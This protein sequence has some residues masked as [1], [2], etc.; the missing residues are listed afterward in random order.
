MLMSHVKTQTRRV[1]TEAYARCHERAV[2]SGAFVKVW[3]GGL[4][5]VLG[6]ARYT[7]M[8]RQQLRD[9]STH[10][11]YCEGYPHTSVNDFLELK[12]AGP[13]PRGQPKGEFHG[14]SRDSWVYVICFSFFPLDI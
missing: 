1:W 4:G 9:M 2:T 6:Y 5:K 10:D 3:C 11:V 7:D 14:L 13:G 8:Y 12:F